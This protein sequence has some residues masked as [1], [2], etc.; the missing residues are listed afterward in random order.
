MNSLKSESAHNAKPLK[1]LMVSTEYPPMNG[2]VGRYTSNLTRELNRLG[3]QV[4]VLSNENGSGDFI[5]L[6]PKNTKNSSVL[7]KIVNEVKPDIVHIQFEH[8]LYGLKLDR[9]NPKKTNT[10]IDLFYDLCK[11]PIVTTFHTAFNFKQWMNTVATKN[12]N[13]KWKLKSYAEKLLKYWTHFLNYKSFNNLNKDKIN[14]SKRGIVFFTVYERQNR[15][16]RYN[17][18]WF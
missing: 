5:G 17:L 16:R 9:L 3:L 13:E 18:S 15:R 1:V 10:N 11:T 4:Q 14:K 2:G 8:G 7:L 6:S 12:K